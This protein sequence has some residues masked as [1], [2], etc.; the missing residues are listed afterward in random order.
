MPLDESTPL[1]VKEEALAGLAASVAAGCRP[2]ARRWLSAARS[3]GACE[4]GLRLAIE[5]GLSVRSD[6]TRE[7]ADFAAA[8]Q[9]DPPELDQA[10]R[11]ERARLVEVLACGAA[12]ALNSSEGLERHIGAARS[13]GASHAQ[14]GASLAI[15]H[16]V[17]NAAG[18][19]AANVVQRA[20]VDVA[21]RLSG[22]W[23]CESLRVADPAPPCGCQ[24]ERP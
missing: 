18:D 13:H 4:R 12:L 3:A 16:A 20:G 24:G 11:S 10:F 8:L 9:A 2:C 5:T 21:P 17:R 7:M 19:E 23:C 1:S 14:I 22:K 6:A 15:A